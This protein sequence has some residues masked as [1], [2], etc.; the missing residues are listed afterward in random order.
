VSVDG[1]RGNDVAIFE[2]CSGRDQLTSSRDQAAFTN[3]NRNSYEALGF[4]T[5]RAISGGGQDQSSS[6]AIDFVLQLVGNWQQ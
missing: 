1:R 5:V 2:G 6:S 3:S 4:D